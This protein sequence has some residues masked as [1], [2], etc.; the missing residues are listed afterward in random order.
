MSG[1]PRG[2][3]ALAR[4]LA[5]GAVCALL[6]ACG[7]GDSG[8]D[9]ATPHLDVVAVVNGQAIT[10]GAFERYVESAAGG[11]EEVSGDREA[12]RRWL[13]RM[14][15]E[16]LLIQRG[17]ELGLYR[18]DP[19]A[20]RAI[21][22]AVIASVTSAGEAGEPDEAALRSHFEQNAG[23]FAPSERFAVDVVLVSDRGRSDAEAHGEAEAIASRLRGGEDANALLASYPYASA[24]A[25]AAPPLPLESLA[26]RAGPA[27]ADAVAQLQPGEVSDPVRDQAGYIV[28]ALRERWSAQATPFDEVRSE[29]RGAYQRQRREQALSDTLEALHRDADIR[30]LDRDLVAP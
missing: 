15:D 22:S 18:S 6:A 17:I 13:L 20:R 5:A 8:A 9:S 27:A 16:E 3:R 24:L 2:R 7:D 11:S 10:R 23:S 12:R 1:S 4:L 21:L 14:I 19:A 26:R 28:V 30:I 25:T 29:V